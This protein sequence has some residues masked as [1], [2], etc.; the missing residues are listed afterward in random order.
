MGARRLTKTERRL[1]WIF[2]SGRSGSTW[3]LNLLKA[4]GNV[5]PI[6]E[7]L[8]GA[9]LAAGTAAF[10]GDRSAQTIYEVSRERAAYIFS[11]ASRT[12][13]EPLVR[14]LMLTRFAHEARSSG[15][16]ALIVVKEP[17]GSIAAPF[18]TSVTPHSRL[19]FLLRDGR[20]VVD[21]SIDAAGAAWASQ[22]PRSLTSSERLEI[23]ER[24]SHRW[25][26][27]SIATQTAF[28]A[29]PVSARLMV[30]YEELLSDTAA[31]LGRILTWLGRPTDDAERVARLLAFEAIP[32]HQKGTGH[33]H[34]AAT[35]GLWRET[36]TAREQTRLMEIQGPTLSRFGYI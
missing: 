7:P 21:S 30:R 23:L 33:F 16:T 26:A 28:D 13:W 9:H 15:Q 19:I 17:K 27:G 32:E 29:H 18:L 1:V 25:V 14:S 10:A 11:D 24:Q 3:L 31:E 20:D 36:L 2:G 8:I 5:V 35:P 12:V 34:R 4:C 6:D 22:S